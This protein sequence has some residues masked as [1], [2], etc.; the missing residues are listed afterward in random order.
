MYVLSKVFMCL[1]SCWKFGQMEEEGTVDVDQFYVQF[2]KS[3]S[4]GFKLN[5][6]CGF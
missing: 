6:V 4:V 1:R 2:V 3:D 5:S